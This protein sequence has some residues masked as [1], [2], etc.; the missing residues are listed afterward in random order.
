MRPAWRAP[1]L[2]WRPASD[3][4]SISGSGAD[5]GSSGFTRLPQTFVNR[6]RWRIDDKARSYY[7]WGNFLE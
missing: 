5:D 3:R 6:R 4:T 7:T 1:F 2:G